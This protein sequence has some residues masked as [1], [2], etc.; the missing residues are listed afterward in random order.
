MNMNVLHHIYLY[1]LYFVLADSNIVCARQV[2]QPPRWTRSTA[3]R[4]LPVAPND[5]HD[6]PK[7]MTYQGPNICMVR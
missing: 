7:G 4:R 5:Q 1:T 3:G 2:R 6:L